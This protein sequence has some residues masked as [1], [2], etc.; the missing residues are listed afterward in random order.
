[1]RIER[2]LEL[3]NE[4]SRRTEQEF[5]NDLQL[6]LD[7][8]TFVYQGLHDANTELPNWR[9]KGEALMMKIQLHGTSLFQL[10]SGYEFFSKNFNKTIQVQDLSSGYSILRSLLEAL[11]MYMHIYIIPH[12]INHKKFRYNVWM[13]SNI[14]NRQK[15]ST[16]DDESSKQKETDQKALSSLLKAITGSTY[17]EQ[18]LTEN[19]QTRLLKGSLPKGSKL[20]KSWK[21]IINESD[22]KLDWYS[23]YGL[24]SQHSHSEVASVWAISSKFKHPLYKKNI[25][26]WSLLLICKSISIVL[27]Q[28]SFLGVRYNSKIPVN[29]QEKIEFYTQMA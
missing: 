24:L 19:Q 28:H 21:N 27:S 16:V 10:V 26:V 5:Q 14:L 15:Y 23:I 29:L 1:M 17:F 18:E 4:H 6:M 11:L 8:L 3:L 20:G 25:L 13:Y 7:C 2:L 12:P 9:A 22:L